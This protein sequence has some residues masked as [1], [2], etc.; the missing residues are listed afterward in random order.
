MDDFV[1]DELFMQTGVPQ[2]SVLGPLLF[3]LFINDLQ[4]ASSKLFSIIFADD[5]NLFISGSDINEINCAINSEM[6]KVYNWFSANKLVLNLDKTCYMLF[7][8]KHKDICESSFKIFV[9]NHEIHRAN[10]TK[11]L[12]VQIVRT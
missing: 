3:L 1:S 12:D 5:T 11:F 9:G 8:P 4:F 6:S 2:G 10:F 7:K